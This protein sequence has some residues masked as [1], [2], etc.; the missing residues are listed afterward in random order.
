[1]HSWDDLNDDL[2]GQLPADIESSA[3]S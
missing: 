2:D 3:I 1:M